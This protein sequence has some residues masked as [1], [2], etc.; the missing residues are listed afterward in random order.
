VP[1][2]A[3]RAPGGSTRSST[4]RPTRAATRRRPRRSFAC[5]TARASSRT[6]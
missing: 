4:A 6:P 5:P 2:G 3:A 1:S